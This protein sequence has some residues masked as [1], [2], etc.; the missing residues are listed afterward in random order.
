MKAAKHIGRKSRVMRV[1]WEMDLSDAEDI[2]LSGTLP[3]PASH[4]DLFY[5]MSLPAYPQ[6][7]RAGA[8]R[9]RLPHRLTRTQLRKRLSRVGLR[10]AELSR[11]LKDI[12]VGPSLS[13]NSLGHTVLGWEEGALRALLGNRAYR[14]VTRGVARLF[15]VLD[16]YAHY[17]T[18]GLVDMMRACRSVNSKPVE[19]TQ[20]LSDFAVPD[21]RPEVDM[22]EF[23]AS[24][25]VVFVSLPAL[26]APAQEEEVP[27]VSKC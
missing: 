14:A 20:T 15:I 4:P 12:L 21:G 13:A 10:G 17:V 26:P 6:M 11:T 22:L 8:V 9:R 5:R 3:T 23:M 2:D 1:W 24:R 27:H 7:L 25:P 16:E 18:P 19:C